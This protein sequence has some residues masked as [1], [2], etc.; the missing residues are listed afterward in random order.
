ME[1]I[2]LTAILGACV[3]HSAWAQSFCASDGQVAPVTLVE[4]FIS[5]DCAACWSTLQMTK[6]PPRTLTLDW[7]VP[8]AQGDEAPLSAAAI[9]D[10]QTRLDTLGRAALATSTVTTTKVRGSQSNQLSVGHGLRVGAYIGA[11]I[12]FKT[13][14]KVRS[15][16]PLSAW[17]LLVETIPAGADGTQTEKN[18]VRNVLISTWEKPDEQTKTGQSIFRELRPLNIPQGATLQRLHVAGWVQDAHG[19]VLAAAQSV[20]TTPLENN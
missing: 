17:L 2:L 10:A 20:C 13:H 8:S 18:L 5:A 16:Q 12:E 9:R 11:T 3:A 1:K 4:H 14:A 7:I 6:P 19:R 15:Q